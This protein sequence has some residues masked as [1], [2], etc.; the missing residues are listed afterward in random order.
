MKV[1]IVDDSPDALALAKVR[2]APEGLDI[3]TAGTGKEGIE[4]TRREE[5]DLVLLDIEMPDMSGLE[6]CRQLKADPQLCMIPVIFLTASSG[7]E[8]RA[9]G[10]DLGAVDY[11]AKPFDEIELRARVRAALRTK[12]LQD[13]LI[14][15][16]HIDPLTGLGNRRALMDRLQQEWK[17][18]QRYGGTLSFVMADVDHFKKVNDT[19]GHSVGDRWLG[20]IARILQAQCRGSDFPARYGGEEFALIVANECADDAAR[21]AERCRAAIENTSLPVGK[22]EVRATASF[23]VC[24]S[25]TA[26]D[27]DQLVRLADAALYR[28][29]ESGRNRVE[30]ADRS[31]ATEPVKVRQRDEAESHPRPDTR[32]TCTTI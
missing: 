22:G 8:D 29:K 17:R 5:P 1:L 12:H 26:D 9:R 6:V 25:G 30:V 18:I 32:P 24:D 13:L 4:V 7:S 14:S 20:E 21:L 27:G 3:C 28:A 15:Y 10:L 2:L 16:A 23:G 19:Y 31:D 11:V